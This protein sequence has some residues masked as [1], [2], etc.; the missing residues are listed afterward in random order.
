MSKFVLSPLAES[1]LEEVWNYFS[2]FDE[3]AANRF[4][5]DI[6]NVFDL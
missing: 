1:D 5:H 6:G 3:I 4:I 2:E